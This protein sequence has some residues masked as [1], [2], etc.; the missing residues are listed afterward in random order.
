MRLSGW[1]ACPSGGGGVR[2][3][4]PDQLTLVTSAELAAS[5]TSPH[6]PCL[7]LQACELTQDLAPGPA[8]GP[9]GCLLKM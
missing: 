8:A 4:S 2:D 1:R 5:H 3:L 7:A 9:G 6:V